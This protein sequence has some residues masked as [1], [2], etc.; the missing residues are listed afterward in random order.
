M[1]NAHTLMLCIALGLAACDDD[2]N[3]RSDT[4]TTAPDTTTPDDTNT[5]PDSTPDSDDTTPD[6]DD[7]TPDSEVS[8]PCI[9]D[10]EVFDDPRVIVCGTTLT[11][12]FYGEDLS[13]SACPPYYRFNDTKYPSLEALAAAEDCDATCEYRGTMGV[14]LIGCES[15]FRTG[16]EVYEPTTDNACL[17]A[18]YSTPIGLLSD[19]CL[20]PEK[21]CR[22][23]CN[24]SCAEG[25]I[26]DL[27]AHQLSAAAGTRRVTTAPLG[28]S[29]RAEKNG[30]LTGL[31]LRLTRCDTTT[32]TS[33]T[34]LDADG[35]EIAWAELATPPDGCDSTTDLENG[36]PGPAYFAI[37]GQCLAVQT[38]DTLRLTIQPPLCDTPP[39]G[40]GVGLG[41]ATG[42]PYTPGSLFT[43]DTAVTTEDLSFKVFIE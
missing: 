4:E 33:L 2:S 38:G 20:W 1:R 14:D 9:P 11:F 42:N 29:F 3:P 15:G 17:D 28:Q 21:T 18:V 6:T 13:P 32:P 35:V 39:C 23:D 22:A 31:E 43:G 37:E 16:Y 10:A 7:T 5:P 26:G 30:I 41:Y 25:T 40:D 27:D 19:L 24:P 34:L 12:V 36:P 8:P